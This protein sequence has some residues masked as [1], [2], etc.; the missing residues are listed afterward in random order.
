MLKKEK[1]K[2]KTLRTR[3]QFRFLKRLLVSVVYSHETVDSTIWVFDFD[4]SVQ[5]F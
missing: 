3:M 4:C 2:K 5:I 1:K